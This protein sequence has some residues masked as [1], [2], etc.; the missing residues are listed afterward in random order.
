LSDVHR[1]AE[2]SPRRADARKHEDH[3]DH[4]EHEEDTKEITLH[5]PAA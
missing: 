4:E 5:A 3:E 2:T 1:D